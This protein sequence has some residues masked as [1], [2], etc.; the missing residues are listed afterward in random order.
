MAN[1]ISYTLKPISTNDADLWTQYPWGSVPNPFPP[2]DTDPAQSQ[3]SYVVLRLASVTAA[4]K[5]TVDVSKRSLP[6]WLADASLAIIGQPQYITGTSD[7]VVSSS[8]VTCG[9]ASFSR[10]TAVFLVIPIAFVP[11][12]TDGTTDGTPDYKSEGYLSYVKN[13]RASPPLLDWS[14]AALSLLLAFII[15]AL[16]SFAKGFFLELIDLA[17]FAI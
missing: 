7:V 13:K 10:G 9:A 4:D 12:K 16:V 2:V 15:V 3:L 1:K 8:G 5:P 6:V 14:D 11:L 17:G